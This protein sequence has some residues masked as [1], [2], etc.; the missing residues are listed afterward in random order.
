M[1]KTSVK[2][3]KMIPISEAAKILGVSIDTV[4]R[5]DKSGKLHAER[6]NGK[7]RYFSLEELERIKFE[8]PLSISEAAIQLKISPTT[9]RRLEKKGLISPKRTPS[10][11]RVYDRDVVSA[12]LES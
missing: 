12:F 1:V 11:E 9:L 10:G 3:K 6:L 4:R 7:D 5:W 2:E 8:K